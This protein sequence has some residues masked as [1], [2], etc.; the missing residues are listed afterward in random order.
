MIKYI[1]SFFYKEETP[2]QTPHHLSPLP[3][4]KFFEEI[5]YKEPSND[6]EPKLSQKQQKQLIKYFLH[7]NNKWGL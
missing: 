6:D 4:H 3:Q 5:I 2:T 1:K 7:K